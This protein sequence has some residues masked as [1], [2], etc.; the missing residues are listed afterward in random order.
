MKTIRVVLLIAAGVVGAAIGIGAGVF[1]AQ[2]SIGSATAKIDLV[3]VKAAIAPYHQTWLAERAGWKL[4]PGL[5]NCFDMQPVGGM[6][7]HYINPNLL[8]TTLDP[9][10]P[11]ALVYQQQ[12]DG[13]LRLG[14]VEY[15]VP[16]AAWDAEGHSG[17]P[18]IHGLQP[19]DMPLHLNAA[20]GVYVLHAWVI[21]DNPA[22]TFQ[23]W[24]PDVHCL[25]G[26]A[27][28]MDAVMP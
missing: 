19:Q 6:G 9:L 27:A 24:N 13:K 12:P 7:I 4:L 14:A 21:R 16:K 20:L 23:D 25:A 26:T 1:A 2:A 10:T 8:D 3:R 5:D 15:I 18:V 22:G 28:P 17:V 11:E